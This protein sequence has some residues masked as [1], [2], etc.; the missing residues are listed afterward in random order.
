MITV[1]III[2]IIIVCGENIGIL[3]FVQ[4]FNFY[5]CCMPLPSHPSRFGRRH[6]IS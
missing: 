2:I 1:N 5:V 6:N 3:T 4:I